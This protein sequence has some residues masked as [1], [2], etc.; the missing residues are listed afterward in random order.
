VG[1]H[2]A[3][4]MQS[5]NRLVM[6][7]EGTSLGSVPPHVKLER[8]PIE[9]IRLG[10]KDSRTRV[11][12]DFGSRPVPPFKVHRQDKTVVLTLDHKAALVLRTP[13]A[14][15]QPIA[16]GVER[17][18]PLNIKPESKRAETTPKVTEGAPRASDLSDLVVK[19]SGTKEDLVFV[20]LADRRDPKRIYHLVIDYDKNGSKVRNVTLSD[21]R[22]NLRKFGSN[23]QVK[24]D[25]GKEADPAQ[26]AGPRKGNACV[27]QASPEPRKFQWGLDATRGSDNDESGSVAS[28]SPFSEEDTE[29]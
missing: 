23:A 25:K 1:Q 19:S 9:E 16:P 3:F 4:V 13:P 18:R 20:E 24:G 11:V 8:G 28:K 29:R 21:V 26:A 17:A 14:K 7:L 27:A 5:P 2:K 22:G 10:Q 15:A 6:D 12:V